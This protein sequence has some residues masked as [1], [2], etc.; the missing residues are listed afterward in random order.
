MTEGPTVAYPRSHERYKCLEATRDQSNTSLRTSIDV[1]CWS[2]NLDTVH[3][4]DTPTEVGRRSGAGA[5]HQ[6]LQ[7]CSD[8]SLLNDMVRGVR[9]IEIPGLSK[10]RDQSL[11]GQDRAIKEPP[12]RC[13]S[14]PESEMCPPRIMMGAYTRRSASETVDVHFKTPY[15]GVFGEYSERITKFPI[16]M[17]AVLRT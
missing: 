17:R 1:S 10:E 3:G 14:V 11:I 9:R 16:V 12:T 2:T 13:K 7:Y 4:G 15:L 6:V 8:A 5:L